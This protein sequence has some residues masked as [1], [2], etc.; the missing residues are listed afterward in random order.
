MKTLFWAGLPLAIRR[1]SAGVGGVCAIAGSFTALA[2][3]AAE[4]E[5][6][7]AVYS[8]VS[9]DYVRVKQDDG[10]FAPEPYAFGEGGFWTGFQRDKSIDEIKFEDVA[11][12]IAGPL[13]AQ[14]YLPARNN[15]ETKLL[16]LVY[17]GTTTGSI[18]SPA[19]ET[20]RYLLGH[21]TAMQGAASAHAAV[22]SP[23]AWG[24]SLTQRWTGP[25]GLGNPGSLGASSQASSAISDS[26][27]AV[28]GATQQMQL[29]IDSQN[30][31][32]LGF[33][34]ELIRYEPLKFTPA[35][36]RRDD[37]YDEVG[38]NRYFVVLLAY[39]FQLL[40]KQKKHKLVWEARYSIDERGNDFTAQLAAMTQAASRYFGRSSDGL[41]HR[42]LP[43]TNV[44]FGEFKVIQYQP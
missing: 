16:I 12:T 33:T 17:W 44:K 14:N 13:A 23:G 4:G 18:G 10:S 29:L 8:R 24:I 36:L 2:G 3:R 43:E 20:Y 7:T 32:I 34:D 25:G 22:S 35:R 40:R 41:K 21:D 5:V 1:F 31:K 39:D 15:A 26:M 37:L 28:I 9:D 6:V 27:L 30:A 11:R 38:H 19:S 42:Q